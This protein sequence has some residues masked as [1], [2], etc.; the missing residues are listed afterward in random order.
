MPQDHGGTYKGRMTPQLAE[1]VRKECEQFQ[2]Q[3][4]YAA[5]GWLSYSGASTSK[6]PHIV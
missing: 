2:C 3:E 6:H 4:C 1:Q 5:A